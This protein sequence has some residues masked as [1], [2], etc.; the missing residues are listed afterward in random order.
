MGYFD[1]AIKEKDSLSHHGI[2]GQKWGVRR[3][4]NANGTYTAA[5]KKR[6]GMDLDLNDKSRTNIAKIRQGE[7]RRKLDVAKANVKSGKGSVYNVADLKSRVRSANKEV[8]QMKSID[9][10][11]KRYAKGETITGNNVKV[12][13]AATAATGAS[14]L[15]ATYLNKRISDLGSEGR[16][17]PS[18]VSAAKAANDFINATLTGATV[19]YG[20][21]KAVDNQNIRKYERSRWNGDTTIKKVGSQEYKDVIERNKKK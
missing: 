3:F 13:M 2:R 19:A 8:K 5:G 10:G 9:K 12:Y 18:H 6:Y 21:K 1:D 14:W 17:R 15:A 11:A 4:Q 20:V 7:A 16:L